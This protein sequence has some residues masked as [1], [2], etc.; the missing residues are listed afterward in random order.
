[1]D[2]FNSEKDAS[3]PR[4]SHK[5][6]RIDQSLPVRPCLRP[7]LSDSSIL[8]TAGFRDGSVDR[9]RSLSIGRSLR[10]S[11]DIWV[12][13]ATPIESS[14]ESTR[15]LPKKIYSPSWKPSTRNNFMIKTTR[16]K[17]RDIP[18]TNPRADYVAKWRARREALITVDEPT[19]LSDIMSESEF[20]FIEPNLDESPSDILACKAQRENK[21]GGIAM[22]DP[23]LAASSL[24]P[25]DAPPHCTGS[26][27]DHN[28]RLSSSRSTVS[29]KEVRWDE[30]V[31]IVEP[32]RR[33]PANTL[34]APIEV[35]SQKPIPAYPVPA[36]ILMTPIETR[37]QEPVAASPKATLPQP[38]NV[39]SQEPIQTSIK[40]SL[41]PVPELIY[42][43][44]II[45]CRIPTAGKGTETVDELEEQGRDQ[46][47]E[48]SFMAGV[49][50]LVLAI[51]IA[52]ILHLFYFDSK[53]ALNRYSVWFDFVRNI[54][55]EGTLLQNPI[56]GA[57]DQTYGNVFGGYHRE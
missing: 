32:H 33:P 46:Q 5:T 23:E 31:G 43:R 47:T 36:N 51:T 57:V 13:A 24:V 50:F 16:Q 4:D 21:S 25:Y 39:Y 12:D 49:M 7:R 11:S 44:P 37:F 8:G 56:L 45:K 20:D 53:E 18:T 10:A 9:R 42:Q 28:S 52:S 40:L 6:R 26:I 38:R 48:G 34:I 41:S 15:S 17:A 54:F 27:C 29:Y 2:R 14:T 1:M 55:E 35:F 22:Q 19:A 30:P 3:K